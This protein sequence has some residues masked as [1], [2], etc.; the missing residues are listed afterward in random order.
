MLL[1][2]TRKHAHFF[3]L[4]SIFDLKQNKL[5][6]LQSFFQSSYFAR[7]SETTDLM[8]MSWFL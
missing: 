6:I 4:L 1:F 2:E 7:P 3:N 5:L 8:R